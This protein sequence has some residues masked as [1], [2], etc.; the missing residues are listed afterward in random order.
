MKMYYN[1]VPI[2]SLN[3]KHYELDTNSATM[4]PSD[5]QTGVTAFAK[6]KKVEGT[7]KA[8]EFAMYGDWNTNTPIVVPSTINVVQ[9]GSLN[10][11]IRMTNSVYNMNSLDFTKTQKI[12]EVTIE[13]TVY[14]ISASVQNGMLT[15][16]C[17]NTIEIQLFFGKD[18]YR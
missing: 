4:V 11:P 5:L 3:V 18:N 14:S 16:F 10:Y 13:G 6:G 7:G 15:I 2:K 1:N 12:A 8:F 9:V 17:D